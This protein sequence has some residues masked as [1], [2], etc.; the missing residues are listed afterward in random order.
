MIIPAA[1]KPPSALAVPTS[2]HIAPVLF[3]QP[4]PICHNH[5]REAENGVKT[6]REWA[7]FQRNLAGAWTL[8]T[9]VAIEVEVFRFPAPVEP[10]HFDFGGDCALAIDFVAAHRQLYAPTKKAAR[11]WLSCRLDVLSLS[12]QTLFDKSTFANN[13]PGT[14]ILFATSC[15]GCRECTCAQHQQA[16]S[17]WLGHANVSVR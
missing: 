7:R 10:E 6:A 11:K 12:A 2:D 15:T 14:L 3:L 5:L 9:H 16:E 4:K 1:E 17:R 8:D 13:S